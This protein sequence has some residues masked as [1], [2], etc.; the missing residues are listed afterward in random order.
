MMDRRIVQEG[1]AARGE[2]ARRPLKT[3]LAKS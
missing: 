2:E 3:V 1:K